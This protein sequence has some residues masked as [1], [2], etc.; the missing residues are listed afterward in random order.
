MYYVDMF[1]SKYLKSN[2]FIHPYIGSG[3][4]LKAIKRSYKRVLNI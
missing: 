3:A 2:L 1:K 4:R